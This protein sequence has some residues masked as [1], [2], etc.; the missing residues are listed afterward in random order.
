MS[1]AQTGNAPGRRA[2]SRLLI[3]IGNSRIKW[4]LARDGKL[5]PLHALPIAGRNRPDLAPL[6]RAAAKASSAAIVSVA[7]SGRG[8]AIQKALI[9]VGLPE[10]FILRSSAKA[11]GI[12][13]GYRDP[14]RLGADR[15]A[16]V[17]GAWHDAGGARPVCVI[18]IGTATTVDVVDADGR[19]KG[20]LIVPG[21]ALMTRSLLEGTQ[22]IAPRAQ[23][24][25]KPRSKGLARDTAGAIHQGALLATAALIERAERD[26]RREHGRRTKVYLT[27]GG[28]QAV[29]PLIDCELHH[30]PDL[31]LRG[32]A[33]ES[34]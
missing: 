29:L 11:A 15:W 31:V 28:A 2:A 10:P 1:R 22:G 19:H 34:D 18:D 6:M 26:V 17:I 3:D 32:L 14:W 33:V 8:Q 4:C 25:S 24:S 5:G 9:K 30:C 12:L 13:N 16:A 7:G 23:G 21:P 27:G 20:G